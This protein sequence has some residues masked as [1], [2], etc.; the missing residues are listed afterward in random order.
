MNASDHPFYRDLQRPLLVFS[1]HLHGLTSTVR[2]PRSAKSAP[3]SCLPVPPIVHLVCSFALAFTG[4]TS[5]RTDHVQPISS[6]AL[7][8]TRPQK[9]LPDF[10]SCGFPVSFVHIFVHLSCVS[11]FLSSS[12]LHRLDFGFF[13]FEISKS[14]SYYSC[15]RVVPTWP[16]SSP[17]SS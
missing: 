3:V 13:S 8:S 14:Y 11:L 6:P 7:T 17:S 9:A 15:V 4:Q 5:S 2:S 16:A 10:L 1:Y 12:T